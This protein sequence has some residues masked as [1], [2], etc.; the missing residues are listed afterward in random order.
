MDKNSF[1]ELV[2]LHLSCYGM[3]LGLS[4]GK[5]IDCDGLRV[6]GF[7]AEADGIILVAGANPRWFSILI[8]E[9][10]HFLQWVEKCRVGK[11]F[12][13]HWRAWDGWLKDDRKLSKRVLHTKFLAVRNFELDCEKRAVELIKRYKLPINIQSYIQDANCYMF[14]Y[15]YV[16]KHRIWPQKRIPMLIKHTMP[17]HF[18][19]ANEYNTMPVEYEMLIT[20]HC[21]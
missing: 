7:F 4:K 5:D 1:V 8:H 6:G 21:V 18:L 10:G 14:F 20:K 9:Y 12:N 11:T 3:L 19:K 2:K 15:A 16:K 17:K 13:R